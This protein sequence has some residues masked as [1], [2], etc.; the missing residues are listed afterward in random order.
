L[1]RW[2]RRA[3][4]TTLFPGNDERHRRPQAAPPTTWES[5]VITTMTTTVTPTT[6]T[7]D[8]R[9]VLEADFGQAC[10]EWSEARFRQAAK[11][12]PAHRAAVA[13]WGARI[14]AVLDMYLDAG[15]TR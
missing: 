11:D 4:S 14:D 1:P 9:T 13:E 8:I 7:T 2:S 15:L 5:T 6:T 10:Y 12:T 3:L